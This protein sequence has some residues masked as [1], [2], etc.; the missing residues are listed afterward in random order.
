MQVAKIS[1]IILILPRC[2]THLAGVG[3]M[4]AFCMILSYGYEIEVK[5]DDEFIVTAYRDIYLRGGP[6][7]TYSEVSLLPAGVE[8]EIIERNPTGT[9]LHVKRQ[10]AQG[11]IVLEGWMLSGYLNDLNDLR[12]SQILVNDELA[13]ADPSTINSRSMAQLYAVPVISEISDSMRDVFAEG[14]R[15]GNHPNG[16]TKVGDSLSASELY[17]TLFSRDDVALGPYDYLEDTLAFFG[18]STEDESIAARIGLTTYVVFDPLWA[19]K[20][21]CKANESPLACEYRLKQPSIAMIMFGAND[22]RHMTDAE[23][24][25][26]MRQIVEYS[27]DSGVIPVLSTFSYS[28]D[29]PLWWQSVNFN[30]RLSEIAAEYQVPLINLWSAAR[31]L[32][33]YGLDI[34]NVHLANS[35]FQNLTFATGHEAYYGSS[36][37]NLLTLCMLDELRRTLEMD[38]GAGVSTKDNE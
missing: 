29:E 25:E 10:N 18:P 24:A 2:V 5:A 21:R 17:L 31:V 22:V 37:R 9:W 7:D 27:L 23:F 4:L 11:S 16:V 13:D 35:G 30:L 32:P 15:K 34:D 3:F 1:Q 28:P 36:L 6:G 8:V 26:Q 20:E 38:S 19:D 33:D 12:Y 14:Q